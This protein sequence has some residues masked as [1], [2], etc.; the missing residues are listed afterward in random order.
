[1]A[2]L[3]LPNQPIYL[4]SGLDQSVYKRHVEEAMK[5]GHVD[6]H[7]TIILIIG[8]GGAGKTCVKCLLLDQLPPTV[9]DST[10]VAEQPIRI[11]LTMA[12]S[13]SHTWHAV[14]PDEFD[15]NVIDEICKQ[16]RASR[17]TSATSPSTDSN[18]PMEKSVNEPTASDLSEQEEPQ[19]PN[20]DENILQL[21]DECVS[22]I[23]ERSKAG[24]LRPIELQWVYL[25]DSGGQTQFLEVLQAF[26]KNPSAAI[27]V[28]KL[29]EGLSNHPD[30]PLYRN[31]R[32]VGRTIKSLHSNKTIL[33]NFLRVMQSRH[34]AINKGEHVNVFFVGTHADEQETSS[35]TLADKDKTLGEL[36]HSESFREGILIQPYRRQEVIYPVNAK[37]QDLGS[38]KVAEQLRKDIE[39]A[40]E[41]EPQP[42]P[43]RYF[44]LY[45]LLSRMASKNEVDVLSFKM[46][47]D[48]GARLG[49]SDHDKGRAALKFLTDHNLLFYDQRT[50]AVFISF[51]ALLSMLSA[52][53]YLHY[54]L[55]GGE[56]TSECKTKMWTEFLAL[57]ILTLDILSSKVLQK[58]CNVP[59]RC[60]PNVFNPEKF[61]E[62]LLH[63]NIVA[64]IGRGSKQE[65]LMPCLLPELPPQGTEEWKVNRNLDPSIPVCPLILQYPGRR[66]PVGTFTFLVCYLVNRAA[67]QFLRREKNCNNCFEFQLKRCGMIFQ[68]M[69]HFSEYIEV[70]VHHIVSTNPRYSAACISIF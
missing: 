69:Q 35:E 5:E 56:L 22:E 11:A 59:C 46:C 4:I 17:S 1:M 25:I 13:S 40:C 60:D 68:N 62:L 47:M 58:E 64:P 61:L 42:I 38:K 20:E 70:H 48:V 63:M 8:I 34:A 26:V 27:C 21:H 18:V 29:N 44:I 6:C 51:D 31:G 45:V 54:R 23:L 30:I 49:M 2:N 10:P 39:D 53:V 3:Y 67:W 41:K 19:G 9:R 14:S 33:Q 65:Y 52:I 50:N 32:V 55:Q 57:G 37:E 16:S 66:L 36:E 43:L 28:L 15:Q 7:I 12:K 24:T